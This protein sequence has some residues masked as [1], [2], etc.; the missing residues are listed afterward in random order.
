MN[1]KSSAHDVDSMFLNVIKGDVQISTR[2]RGVH[3]LC[4]KV[5]QALATGRWFSPDPPVSF[6]NKTDRHDTTAE[7][8]LKVTLNTITH[9]TS[10]LN[11]AEI[12]T[13]YYSIIIMLYTSPWLRFELTTSVVIGTDWIGS[14]KSNDHAITAMTDHVINIKSKGK[15]QKDKR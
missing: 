5:C 10:Q 3:I 12:I 14:S 8:L 4:D 2:T 15:C 6:T 7:I 11:I 13:L 9:N 1:I